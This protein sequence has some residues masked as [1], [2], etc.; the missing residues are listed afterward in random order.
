MAHARAN[1]KWVVTHAIRRKASHIVGNAIR[2][3]KLKRQPCFICGNEAQAHHPDYERPL[4]VT[5]L[6]RKHHKAAH[7]I[8]AEILYA[9]G[10]RQTFHF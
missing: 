5:W 9:A 1:E 6:C 4:D 3:G 8:V 10:E 2:D 7:R